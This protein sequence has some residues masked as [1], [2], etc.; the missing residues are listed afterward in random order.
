GKQPD[1][2]KNYWYRPLPTGNIS[3]IWLPMPM[4]TIWLLRPS[5]WMR[6]ECLNVSD[7]RLTVGHTGFA[8]D[9]ITSRWCWRIPFLRHWIWST[10]E[11]KNRLYYKITL[12]VKKQIL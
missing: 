8:N 3:R 12:W 10:Q 4:I 7:P 2:W 9:P 6:Q 1:G 5:W 11:K